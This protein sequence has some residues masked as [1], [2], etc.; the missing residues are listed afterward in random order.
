MKLQILQLECTFMCS[1]LA[2]VT[3]T[4]KQERGSE[5]ATIAARSEWSGSY[6]G[7]DDSSGLA[8]QVSFTY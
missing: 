5:R 6:G 3:F 1:C 4:R 2:Q 7:R 8:V